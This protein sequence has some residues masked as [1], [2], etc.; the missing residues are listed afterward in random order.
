MTTK[1]KVFQYLKLHSDSHIG[2]IALGT[3]LSKTNVTTALNR[4]QKDGYIR[5]R[6][7][8]YGYVIL[9]TL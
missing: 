4:L 9:T 6:V 5:T 1:D 7:K 8:G 3:G 2:E